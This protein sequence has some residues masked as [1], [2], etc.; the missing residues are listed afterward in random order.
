M[1]EIIFFGDVILN[2]GATRTTI[3]TNMIVESENSKKQQAAYNELTQKREKAARN[4]DKLTNYKLRSQLISQ[5]PNISI[6]YI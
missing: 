2:G 6:K 4:Y 3:P 1:K 5:D